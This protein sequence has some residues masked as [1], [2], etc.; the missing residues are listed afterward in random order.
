MSQFWKSKVDNQSRGY[1][2]CLLFSV[3]APS[4]VKPGEI[5]IPPI[6][7]DK[8]K[9]GLQFGDPMFDQEAMKQKIFRFEPGSP[10]GQLGIK[11]I[12]LSHVGSSLK[13]EM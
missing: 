6:D 7:S 11:P 3:P 1:L 12:D 2:N 8:S 4:G 5:L 13:D 10:C 9:V